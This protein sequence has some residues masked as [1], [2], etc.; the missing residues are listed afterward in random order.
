MS[1]APQGTDLA[2]ILFVIMI[3]DSDGKVKNCKLR[4]FAVTLELSK[5]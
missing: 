3:S 5:M 4:S 1:G 2:A